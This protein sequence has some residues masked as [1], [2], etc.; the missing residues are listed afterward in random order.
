MAAFKRTSE[1][2]FFKSTSHTLGLS[3]VFSAR[4]PQKGGGAL[5]RLLDVQ[6]PRA[7]VPAPST[8]WRTALPR[9]LAWLDVTV[10]YASYLN[11]ISEC[12]LE[13]GLSG[14]PRAEAEG[15]HASVALPRSRMWCVCCRVGESLQPHAHQDLGFAEI[16]KKCSWRPVKSL[17]SLSSPPADFLGHRWYWVSEEAFW[18]SSGEVVEGGNTGRV[19]WKAYLAHYA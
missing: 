16:R 3:D 14:A 18:G 4:S 11:F 17:S 12:K 15:S 13:T 5:L 7:S 2:Y 10:W 8:M 6:R 19:S 9:G 1:F